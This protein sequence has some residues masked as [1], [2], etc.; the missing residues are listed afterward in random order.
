[1]ADD[2]IRCGLINKV[3]CRIEE[4]LHLY[5]LILLWTVVFVLSQIGALQHALGL[6]REFVTPVF[7]LTC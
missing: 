4:K 2:L 3:R 1:M 7:L 5:S 6:S